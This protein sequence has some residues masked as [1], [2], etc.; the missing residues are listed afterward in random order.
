MENMYSREISQK[1]WNLPHKA[2]EETERELTFIDDII[3]KAH[4]ERLLLDNLY[5]ISTAFD[6]G[7]GYGRFSMLLAE[8]GVHV[9]HFDISAPMIDK[10]KELADKRGVSDNMTFVLGSLEDLSA[11]RNNSYDL[12]ISF[13][14]PISYTYPNHERVLSELSRI[15][16]KRL[17]I[18]VYSRLASVG[19]LFDPAQKEKYIL[20]ENS[21]DNFVRW[22]LDKAVELRQ[23]FKPDIAAARRQMVDGLPEPYDTT[24]RAYS[25][26]GTPFP[27]SYGFMPDELSEI[28]HHFGA[29]NVK[30]SAPG[31]LSRTIPREV[32]INIMRGNEIKSEFLKF[33]Y[34]FDSQPGVVGL[35]KDNL[36]AIAELE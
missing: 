23:E 29:K 16:A 18:S 34:E 28:L 25:E 31:A 20:N 6:G 22:T 24:L 8:R 26:G 36:V 2:T 30:L 1:F 15:A 5:D 10:A 35:G 9:T 21:R 27:V 3:A 33:C 17:C 19:Y 7:A 12:V 13:D 14:A 32:L 11:F 4:I